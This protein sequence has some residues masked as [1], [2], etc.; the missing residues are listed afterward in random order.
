MLLRVFAM[1]LLAAPLAACGTRFPVEGARV[2]PSS[3]EGLVTARAL[4]GEDQER[5]T[6]PLAGAQGLTLGDQEAIDRVT[7][8]S[9][10]AG[11]LTQRE[12][13]RAAVA[14]A[15]RRRAELEGGL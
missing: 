5:R 13:D 14:S 9:C 10:A 1:A 4:L 11:A 3:T 7:D 12:C 6:V 2:S 8:A 15:E